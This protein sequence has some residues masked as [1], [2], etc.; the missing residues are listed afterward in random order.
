MPH[1]TI[2]ER[3]STFHNNC[4]ATFTLLP[5]VS[6]INVLNHGLIAIRS[7]VATQ[8][9]HLVSTACGRCAVHA[10]SG[11]IAVPIGTGFRDSY[12]PSLPGEPAMAANV[13][14]A[15]PALHNLKL[16]PPAKVPDRLVTI[17]VPP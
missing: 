4:Y 1:R 6:N 3:R 2:R 13:P 12:R 17:S 14:V 11:Q 5:K 16:S 15:E 7:L 8:H 9:Q 10:L